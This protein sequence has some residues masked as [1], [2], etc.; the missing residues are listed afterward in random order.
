[1]RKPII[2]GNWKMHKTVAEAIE[3]CRILE[4]L[5][6]DNQVE[7]VI[8]AP[9]TCL[10][11]L[12]ALGMKKAKIA[13]Q[14]MFYE[15]QGA[16]TGEISPVMLRDVG[17][18]Y[19][20][21]G[22][23]ERREYFGETDETVN[24][25]VHTALKFDIKPIVCVGESLEQ[26]KN[27][28]TESLVTSQVEQAFSGV[29]EADAQKIVVAYEPIWAIGTGETAS[30]EEANRVIKIIRATLKNLYSEEVAANIRIQ[31]GGSVK[32]EN[33]KELME[34]SDIDGALVGGASLNPE[35]FASM[36]NYKSL[37]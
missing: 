34:Q 6:Q 22:H 26:R 17:C 28:Q 7:T 2:A 13:A 12:A 10:S 21:I 16:Y 31:Y 3:A 30:A 15:E 32:L 23:S 11:A 14:N 33:I 25:K 24:K 29:D 20:I 35:T 1:M 8:C 5:V 18:D 9:F 27:G 36:I 19:V 4:T 37:K